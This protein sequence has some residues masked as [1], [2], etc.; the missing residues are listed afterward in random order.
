MVDVLLPFYASHLA[1]VRGK[2]ETL[3]S[4]E[5]EV[6]AADRAAAEARARRDFA[7]AVRYAWQAAGPAVIACC[8]LSGSGKTTLAAERD[9]VSMKRGQ[10]TSGLSPSAQRVSPLLQVFVRIHPEGGHAPGP[11][12]FS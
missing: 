3:K 11:I 7:R 4:L 6:E 12:F 9:L 2:V 10:S 1:C 5:P 8:G